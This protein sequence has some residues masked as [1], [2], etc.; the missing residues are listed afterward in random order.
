M[1]NKGFSLVELIVVIAIMAILVG[2]AVPV[3]T[4]YISKANEAK[5]IQLLEE[6]NSAFMTVAIENQ[7]DFDDLTN[8]NNVIKVDRATGA[9]T[10]ELYH[11]DETGIDLNPGVKEILG[12][13]LKFNVLAGVTYNRAQRCFKA[14]TATTFGENG[15]LVLNKEDIAKLKDST[16]LKKM[17]MA[18]LLGEV[19]DVAEYAKMLSL[20]GGSSS[21][22]FILN[23]PEFKK[24]ALAAMQVELGNRTV[25]QALNEEMARLIPT[26]IAQGM[27]QEEAMNYISANAAVLFA[28]QNAANMSS[29]E[30]KELLGSKNA[31]GFIIQDVNS[32]P[33]EALGKAAIAY[34]V[35]LAY[36]TECNDEAA[37]QAL[38]DDPRQAIL[39]MDSLPEDHAFWSYLESDQGQADIEGFLSSMQMI[40]SSTGSKDAVEKLMLEGFAS[41]DLKGVLSGAVG[42]ETDDE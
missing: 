14:G 26:L 4:G 17:T 42:E 20:D 33:G 25:D 2:V 6:I 15:Y 23:S 3:Y 18:Q 41:D 27:S 34:G 24:S 21:Y 16:F 37:K 11:D 39:D 1:K 8:T 7:V 10:L 19:S 36:A 9:I 13:E 38:E 12:E 31:A 30:V 35:Y 28:A 5:D 32:K 29:T 40:N 22:E